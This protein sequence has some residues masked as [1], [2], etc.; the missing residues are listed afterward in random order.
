LRICKKYSEIRLITIRKVTVKRI[1][2]IQS[3][4]MMLYNNQIKMTPKRFGMIKI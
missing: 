3:N 1:L 2:Q 4:L